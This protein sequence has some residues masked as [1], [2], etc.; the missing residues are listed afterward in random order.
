MAERPARGRRVVWWLLA[1]GVLAGIAVGIVCLLLLPSPPF[2]RADYNRVSMGMEYEDAEAAL[3]RPPGYYGV[4]PDAPFVLSAQAG[5]TMLGPG[6]EAV[7]VSAGVEDFRS[8]A[9][10]ETVARISVWSAP[11]GAVR[12]ISKDGRV[13]GKMHW[14]SRPWGGLWGWLRGPLRRLGW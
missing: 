7:P 13:V 8:R 14:Q 5:L 10:G 6:H 9:T 2:G 4:S 3:G 12:L 11:G 1:A